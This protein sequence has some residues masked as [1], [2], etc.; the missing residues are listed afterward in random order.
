MFLAAPYLLPILPYWAAAVLLASALVAL[1]VGI[2]NVRR[3]RRSLRWPRVTGTIDEVEVEKDRAQDDG[4]EYRVIVTYDFTARNQRQQ[5][6]EYFPR[7]SGQGVNREAAAALA[8][9]YTPGDAIEVSWDPDHF[10]DSTI[11][12]GGERDGRTWLN[13]AI[14]WTIAA[15]AIAYL[16]W[17]DAP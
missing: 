6:K 1:I 4:E 17:R 13:A 11:N 7:K 15:G 2:R 10:P 16:V 3:G 8:E 14:V 5:G 12:P 9:R